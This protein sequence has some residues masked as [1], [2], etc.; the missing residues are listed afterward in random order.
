M[1]TSMVAFTAQS[2]S[3]PSSG[4]AAFTVRNDRLF[5]AYDDA[6]DEDAYFV[7]VL[8]LSYGSGDIDV[9][10]F[11]TGDT[12]TS[13]NAY[14]EVSWEAIDNAGPDL[15]SDSF[16]TAQAVG[17]TAPS[18]AGVIRYVVLTFTQ[19]QADG[20]GAGE[21]FRLRVRRAG[22]NGSDTL[23]GDAHLFAVAIDEQ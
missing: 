21:A 6:A 23:S 16:A 1:T 17:D 10:L 2:A 3:L 19:A 13:G 4:A 22:T 11:W 18:T 5:L 8:P 12:A 7:G 20:V 9:T 14:W 15:D